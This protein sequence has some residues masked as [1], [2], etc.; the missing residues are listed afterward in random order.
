MQEFILKPFGYFFRAIIERVLQ[1]PL[2]RSPLCF[3][4]YGSRGEKR[5][6]FSFHILFIFSN[7]VTCFKNI[8]LIFRTKNIVSRFFYLPPLLENRKIIFISLLFFYHMLYLPQPIVIL[9]KDPDLQ[10]VLVMII[11]NYTLDLLSKLK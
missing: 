8:S 3:F 1:H 7:V 2:I 6:I 9:Q 10:N 5:I 11:S 4:K